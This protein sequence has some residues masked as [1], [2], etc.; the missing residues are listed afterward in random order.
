[1]AVKAFPRDSFK[2]PSPGQHHPDQLFQKVPHLTSPQS[3]RQPDNISPSNTEG[4]NGFLGKTKRGGLT[5]N[6]RQLFSSPPKHFFLTLLFSDSDV[7]D[8]LYHPRHGAN[9]SFADFAL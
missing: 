4:S 3:N 8:N 9:V 6:H 5:R 7:D 2:V 1:M